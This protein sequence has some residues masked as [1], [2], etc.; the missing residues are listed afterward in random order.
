VKEFKHASP[1][2]HVLPDS[3]LALICHC[4]ALIGQSSLSH[5]H[6]THASHSKNDDGTVFEFIPFDL[7]TWTLSSA[8]QSQMKR[9]PIEMAETLKWVW[10]GKKTST[11]LRQVSRAM[12]RGVVFQIWWLTSHS[13]A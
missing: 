8:A 10:K 3:V 2:R 13:R 11:L 6:K 9:T 1:P 4:P 5:Q 12:V 7:Q